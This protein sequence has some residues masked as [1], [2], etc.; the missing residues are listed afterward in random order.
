MLVTLEKGA[1]AMNKMRKRGIRILPGGDYGFIWNPIGTNARDLEHFVKLFG[2]AP[3]E[4]LM[5][6]TKYGGQMMGMGDELG[7]IKPGYL[8]DLLLVDG[9]PVNGHH[10]VAEARRAANGDEGRRIS[11]GADAMP[12]AARQRFGPPE[13]IEEQVMNAQSKTVVDTERQAREQLAACYRIFARREMDDLIFTHLSAKIPEKEGRY[14]FHPLRHAVDEVTTCLRLI[15][16]VMRSTAITASIRA[17]WIVH[18]VV[19][20]AVPDAQ[21]VM[22]LHTITGT[23][24]SA[25]RQGLLP[26]NQ[27]GVTFYGKIAYHDYDG[28]VCGPKSRRSSSPIWPTNG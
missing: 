13:Y 19:Y 14:P 8:A 17:G 7:L 26:V 25:Q 27:F 4:V 16:R 21:S 24:V 5:M 23:A 15:S 28:P 3:A 1:E 6:A 2:F 10:A 22:H 9:D 11:Q 12:D 18:R 20:D